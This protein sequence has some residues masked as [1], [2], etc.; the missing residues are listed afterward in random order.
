[1][2]YSFLTG[3][4][5]VHHRSPHWGTSPPPVPQRGVRSR[6]AVRPQDKMAAVGLVSVSLSDGET[7]AHQHKLFVSC[8]LRGGS[9]GARGLA[10]P[11]GGKPPPQGSPGPYEPPLPPP[12]DT[13]SVQIIP[14]SSDH[15]HAWIP[16]LPD[17]HWS[18]PLSAY[19]S[20]PSLYRP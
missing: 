3:S 19:R 6:D 20:N 9:T 12:A 5:L 7:P 18:Q 4:W 13:P 16:L 2:S 15:T 11:S 14:P 10:S 17:H 8:D 1:M